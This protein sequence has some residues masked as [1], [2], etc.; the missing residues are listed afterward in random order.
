MCAHAPLLHMGAED[1]HLGPNV[2]ALSNLTQLS[3]LLCTL[4][5]SCVTFKK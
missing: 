3:H 2:N 5:K 1:L 4:L